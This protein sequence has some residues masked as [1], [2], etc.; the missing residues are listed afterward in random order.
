VSLWAFTGE[1]SAA[2]LQA[3][4]VK[5]VVIGH[6][7]RRQLFGESDA[8]VAKKTAAA[9]QVGLHPILCIGETLAEREDDRVE[10]V[11]ERQLRKGIE[12]CSSRDLGSVVIAYEP[13]WAIGTVKTATAARAQEAHAFIRSVTENM[14]WTRIYYGRERTVCE[15]ARTE[16]DNCEHKGTSLFAPVPEIPARAPSL[17]CGTLNREESPNFW[18]WGPKTALGKYPFDARDRSHC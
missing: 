18:E 2:M 7:E 4:Q 1:V 5:H 15:M 8:I 10:E 12:D 6:S 16:L 17:T 9:L 13:V 14:A 3:L 11:L